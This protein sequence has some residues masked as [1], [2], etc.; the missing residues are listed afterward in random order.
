MDQRQTVD[1]RGV[2]GKGA[3]SGGARCGARGVRVAGLVA[4]IVLAGGLARG[5]DFAVAVDETQTLTAA[6]TY[7][8]MDVQ[9]QL[10]LDG[11]AAGVS[12]TNK[13]TLVPGRG[14][15]TVRNNARLAMWSNDAFVVAASDAEDVPT[16]VPVLNLE[17]PATV[18]MDMVNKSSV[19]SCVAVS[20][21]VAWGRRSGY[22]WSDGTFGKGGPWRV[23]VA[24]GGRLTFDHGNQGGHLNDARDSNGK[25]AAVVFDGAGDVAFAHWYNAG[26][27]GAFAVQAGADIANTGCLFMRG[28]KSGVWTFC[29]GS[30]VNGPTNVVAQGAPCAWIVNAG[31]DVTVRNLTWNRSGDTVSGTGRVTVDASEADVVVAANV[32]A[33]IVN[34]TGTPNTLAFVKTG[35]HEAVFAVTNLPALTVDAGC[36]V[37]TNDCRMGRLAVSAGATLIVDGGRIVCSDIEKPGEIVCR[38]GGAVSI[39]TDGTAGD[40]AGMLRTPL[41]S[42]T[43]LV[44]TG[45]GDLIVYEPEAVAGFVHVA[46][47]AL[48]FSKRGLSDKYFRLTFKECW[49]FWYYEYGNRNARLS[50]KIGLYDSQDK[51]IHMGWGWDAA[52][53]TPAIDLQAGQVTAPV[54]TVVV[55]GSLHAVVIGNTPSESGYRPEF[56]KVQTNAADTATWQEITARFYADTPAI[57]GLNFNTGWEHGSPRVWTVETSATGQDG[58]WRTV[59]DVTNAP[60]PPN[61]NHHGYIGGDISKPAYH[62]RYVEPGVTGLADVLQIQVDGGAVLDFTS[63]TGGQTVD[64]IVVDLAAGGGT[65]GTV[66]NVVFAASGVVELKGVSR[67]PKGELPLVCA[68]ASGEENL[69]NWTVAVAGKPRRGSVSLCGERLNVSAD[70]MLLLI[71]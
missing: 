13:L 59:M 67:L 15:V 9:G 70:G 42:M 71:R 23:T 68:A 32:P 44:K 14:T 48:R 25:T 50:T 1:K 56:D 35:T 21:T 28:D 36:A 52:Y 4:A 26:A 11:E 54:G 22:K 7:G 3:F 45:E 46:G 41:W 37:V 66:S 38:N 19:T 31:A 49:P 20:G 30:R 6:A 27:G 2:M 16:S 61:N 17:G 69:A 51:P 12:V 40:E 53:G 18:T 55:S 47:G 43:E 60:S 62:F 10:I 29:N 63:K 58:S 33:C 39:K 64:R 65:V 5:D 24:A 8:N 34:T 57:D